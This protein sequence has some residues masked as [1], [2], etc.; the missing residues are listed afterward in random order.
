M[1]RFKNNAGF[2]IIEAMMAITIIGMV[3]APVFV[4]ETNVFEAVAR[5]AQSFHRIILSKQ[6][7]FTAFKEQPVGSKEFK[8]E[9]TQENPIATMQYTFAPVNKKSSLAQLNEMYRKQAI[10]SG[11]D[12]TSPEGMA[13]QFV[14]QPERPQS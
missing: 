9:R 6:F 12:K 13:V 10:T 11:A 1:M 2:S 3:L 14:Y 8:F 4:L 7:M 5:L